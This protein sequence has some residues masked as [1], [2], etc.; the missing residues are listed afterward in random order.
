LPYNGLFKAEND[1]KLYLKV[2]TFE[3]MC[4]GGKERFDIDLK[5]AHRSKKGGINTF[6]RLIG[7]L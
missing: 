7:I 3:P 5:G 6:D 2:L 1:L 4:E